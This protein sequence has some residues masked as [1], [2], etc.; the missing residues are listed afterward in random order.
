MPLDHPIHDDCYEG[1]LSKVIAHI[2]HNNTCPNIRGGWA[3]WT[4]LHCSAMRNHVDVVNYLLTRSEIDIH[5]LDIYG[6][7]PLH[8]ACYNGHDT[9]VTA[10]LCHGSALDL[11]KRD[12]FR[13]YTPRD[14]A[15]KNKHT[16][17]VCLLDDFERVG[18]TEFIKRQEETP[19]LEEVQKM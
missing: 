12:K 10:L 17:V 14:W 11:D 19:L 16:G 2:E 3:R 15:V 6:W 18:E 7:T 5:A 1:I 9:I 13:K 8:V 4:P